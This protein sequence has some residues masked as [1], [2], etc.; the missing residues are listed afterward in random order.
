[1][2]I[3]V[4]ASLGQHDL[5]KTPHW[6][7][8]VS[9]FPSL[10]LFTITLKAEKGMETPEWI[11]GPI[12]C[13]PSKLGRVCAKDESTQGRCSLSL[14]KLVPT[15]R[16]RCLYATIMQCQTQVAQV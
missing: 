11:S 4:S 14:L 1:M 12:I 10:A 6:V 5:I 3:C 8:P 13:N 16:K 9:D 7:A 2:A 15:F